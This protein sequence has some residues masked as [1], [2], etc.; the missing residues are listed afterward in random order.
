MHGTRRCP[1]KTDDANEMAPKN[2]PVRN[3]DAVLPA[4]EKQDGGLAMRDGGNGVI[5]TTT[6]IEMGLP[7]PPGCSQTF[8]DAEGESWEDFM[9]K[10]R[11]YDLATD[12]E[13]ENGDV[14]VTTLL[15]CLDGDAVEVYADFTYAT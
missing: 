14:Q 15:M 9:I 10:F 11:M 3:D 7:K 2:F 1:R 6:A 5:E 4:V 12:L 8:M 13:G